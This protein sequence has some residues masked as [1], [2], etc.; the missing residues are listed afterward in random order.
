LQNGKVCT[1][2][3][4]NTRKA[5]MQ[6]TTRGP[7]PK[8]LNYFENLR[9]V[10]RTIK[11]SNVIKAAMKGNRV[12]YKGHEIGIREAVKLQAE[13]PNVLRDMTPY[14]WEGKVF[15]SFDSV[16]TEAFTECRGVLSAWITGIRIRRNGRGAQV[17]ITELRM[18][19]VL[20]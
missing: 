12:V 15:S 13:L 14:H 6:I 7:N 9:K 5:N 2:E 4:S 16:F 19:D 10:V 20:K 8:T 11:N 1:L 17:N 3:A 18:E